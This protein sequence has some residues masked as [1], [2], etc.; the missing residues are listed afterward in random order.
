MIAKDIAAYLHSEKN[1]KKPQRTHSL[2]DTRHLSIQSP[3]EMAYE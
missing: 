3:P 2:Q 1:A